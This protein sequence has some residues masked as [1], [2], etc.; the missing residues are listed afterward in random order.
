M[1]HVTLPA[2]TTEE[3]MFHFVVRKLIEQGRPALKAN[4]KPALQHHSNP[5]IGC[6][7]RILGNS[8]YRPMLERVSSSFCAYLQAIHDGPATKDPANFVAGVKS[9]ARRVAAIY[10]FTLPLEAL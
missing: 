5:E 6:S 10:G 3:A 2:V 8:E 7:I 4:G 9:L 1:K